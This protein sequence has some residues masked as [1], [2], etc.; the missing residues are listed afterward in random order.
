VNATK[1]EPLPA[2]MVATTELVA[3]LMTGSARKQSSL[4]PG[5]RRLTGSRGLWCIEMQSLIARGSGRPVIWAYRKPSPAR[6]E[7]QSRIKG[8][9]IS[10]IPYVKQLFSEWWFPH[11]GIGVFGVGFRH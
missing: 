8:E 3:V 7:K 6:L 10:F 4:Q 2:G 9:K 11:Y 5:I 1:A